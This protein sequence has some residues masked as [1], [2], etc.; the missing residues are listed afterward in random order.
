MLNIEVFDKNVQDYESWYDKY[1]EVYE[2][3]L[4]ALREQFAKLP[5]NI[6]GIQVGVGTGR[7]AHPL[8]IKE[9]IEPSEEM[10]KKAINRNVEIL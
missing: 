7:F 4:A 9:G 10:A 5:E 2:S 3:E 1:P 8:G 6:S